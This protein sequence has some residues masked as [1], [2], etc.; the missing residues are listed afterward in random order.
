M[1][2]HKKYSDD[3]FR[4]AGE[5]YPL[6]TDNG[7]WESVLMRITTPKVDP[8]FIAKSAQN[9]NWRYAWLLLLFLIPAGIMFIKY[10]P[11]SNSGKKNEDKSVIQSSKEN[12]TNS[13]NPIT[14]TVENKR[15][16]T[17]SNVN[18]GDLL[19]NISR[20]NSNL[21]GQQEKEISQQT[22]ST[23]DIVSKPTFLQNTYLPKV[24]GK[25]VK[26]YNDDLLSVDQ[27]NK[28]ILPDFSLIP[29][30]SYSTQE[31]N[32]LVAENNAD[33]IDNSYSKRSVIHF[34]PKER[35]YLA[36]S[37]GP[38]FSAVKSQPIDKTGYSL[39]MLLGYNVNKNIDI[40]TG[41]L[42][43][44]KYFNARGK[45]FNQEVIKTPEGTKLVSLKG[46]ASITQIPLNVIYNF[47]S[48]TP[49]HFFVTANLMTNVIHSET[50]SYTLKENETYNEM[51]R[52]YKKGSDNL[53]SNL[54]VGVGYSQNIG[55]EWKLSAEP[56]YQYPLS[57]IGLGKLYIQS[58]GINIKI[59]KA[60]KKK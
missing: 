16:A 41:V 53:F 26:L 17:T 35:F 15:S 4:E 2:E 18:S 54:S 30:P 32:E 49:S 39:G 11:T 27:M 6:N 1:D 38:S 23:N 42:F 21:A 36:I 48:K 56:Y 46:E 34:K 44:K 5:N 50:Y 37:A 20:E 8:P 19:K 14:P 13:V 25:T 22:F 55:S 24:P 51:S 3:L 52:S 40:E 33:K 12:P 47:K 60:I 45:E 9:H 43:V 28:K 10:N 31:K 59:S 7:N 57:G 29:L 58:Y